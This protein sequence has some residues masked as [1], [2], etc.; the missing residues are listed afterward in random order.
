MTRKFLTTPTTEAVVLRVIL[1]PS[2]MSL[3]V[4]VDDPAVDAW[5]KAIDVAMES[6]WAI[7]VGGCIRTMAQHQLDHRRRFGSRLKVQR[8]LLEDA[9]GVRAGLPPRGDG[10]SHR[11]P[12]MHMIS[13]GVRVVHFA[14]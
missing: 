5:A 11:P 1:L 7:I 14:K 6:A 8:E 9:L 3:A 10:T 2:R 12:V 13:T 4:L